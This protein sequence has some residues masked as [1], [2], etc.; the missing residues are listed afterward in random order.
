MHV[1]AVACFETPHIPFDASYFFTCSGQPEID[2]F[3]ITRAAFDT[4]E[5]DRC[6]MHSCQMLGIE[7]A[8]LVSCKANW[9]L[10]VT[11]CRLQSRPLA[12]KTRDVLDVAPSWQ[13]GARTAQ[14]HEASLFSSMNEFKAFHFKN[15]HKCLLATL[16]GLR[17]L[18]NSTFKLSKRSPPHTQMCLRD[19][20][21]RIII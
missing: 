16:F 2:K 5:A 4:T 14:L 20:I 9:Q 13:C 17:F 15:C 8:R 3:L 11:T 1:S 18:L 19:I 12:N 10:N 7:G 21:A 6:F